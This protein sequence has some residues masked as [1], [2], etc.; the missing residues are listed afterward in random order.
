MRK[1][2]TLPIRELGLRRTSFWY[3]RRGYGGRLIDTVGDLLRLSPSDF[4]Q[5]LVGIGSDTAY[6]LGLGLQRVLELSE[7]EHATDFVARRLQDIW[8]AEGYERYGG[9]F[10]EMSLILADRTSELLERR[11][12]V[13]KTQL[14][15]FMED[16]VKQGAADAA[17]V[18][19]Y[20]AEKMPKLFN[21]NAA[22]WTVRA[23]IEYLFNHPEEK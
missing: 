20:V 2:E 7:D 22:D 21:R 14:R 4:G 16:A 5:R 17:A 18:H 6:A 23:A 1:V 10:S 19:K 12:R 11:E 15:S 13:Q 8:V 9:E 3:G